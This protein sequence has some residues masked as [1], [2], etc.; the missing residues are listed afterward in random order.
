MQADRAGAP[1]TI[2]PCCRRPL[3]PTKAIREA[4]LAEV[5]GYLKGKSSIWIAQNVERKLRNFLRVC[6][7]RSGGIAEFSEH[8]AD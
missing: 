5:I 1:E 6:P 8:E 2:C 3:T 4:I 7:E